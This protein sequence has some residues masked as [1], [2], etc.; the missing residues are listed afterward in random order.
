SRAFPAEEQADAPGARREL[1]GVLVPVLA[2]GGPPAKNWPFQRFAAAAR[3]LGSGRPWL[4]ALGP[5]ER[6]LEPPADAVVARDW[7]L[8]RLGAVLARAGLVLGNDSGVTH[9][10][11]A[12]GAETLALFGPT[13]PALGA[14]LGPHAAVP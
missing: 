8:R 13:D 11:A 3:A 12:A 2:G 5:A 4:L 1:R 9:L 14:P 7:P 6:D 10:A